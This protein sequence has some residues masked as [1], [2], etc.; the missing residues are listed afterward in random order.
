MNALSLTFAFEI[1]ITVEAM[2]EVGPTPKGIRR[3]VPITGGTFQGPTL[4]GTVVA[5]G[6]DWQTVRSDGVTEIEARYLLQT[7]EGALI[8]IVNQGLRHGPPEV[9][10]RLAEGEIVDPSTYYF[11]TIPVFETAAPQHQWLTQYLF[12]ATGIRHPDQV[13][14]Q[15]YQLL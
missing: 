14:I 7:Q 4:A 13:L 11:R 8:T 3:V 2:S 6:Y 9:M 1:R 12:V 10:Q 5:G 15:V